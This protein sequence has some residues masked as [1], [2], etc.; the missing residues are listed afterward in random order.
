[1]A[2][3]ERRASLRP[4]QC[5]V[6]A[7]RCPQRDACDCAAALRAIDA[8]TDSSQHGNCAKPRAARSAPSP[9][10]IDQLTADMRVRVAARA[11]RRAIDRRV[12]AQ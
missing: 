1:M 11:T 5:T 7:L 9:R 8:A 12:E 4:G 3:G 10:R 6:R 2:F